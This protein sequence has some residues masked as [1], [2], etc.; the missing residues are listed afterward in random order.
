VGI[1]VRKVLDVE[2]QIAGL[3]QRGIGGPQDLC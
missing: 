2:Q 3:G 1:Q